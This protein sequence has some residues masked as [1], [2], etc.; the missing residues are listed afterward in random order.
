MVLA[1]ET[2][3]QTP[4]VV[5]GPCQYKQ[6]Q[7]TATIISIY[8]KEMAKKARDS[9]YG[10]PFYQRYKVMFSFSPDQEIEEAWAQVEGRQFLLMLNN[11]HYPGPKF[12]EKYGIKQGKTFDCYLKVITKGT[13]TPVLIEFPTINLSDYFENE[14]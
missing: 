8:K 1:M 4:P 5:G 12:L 2:E 14:N 10:G 11:S 13:C 6:Y 3:K 7:G 9:P